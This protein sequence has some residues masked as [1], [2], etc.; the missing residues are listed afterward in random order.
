MDLNVSNGT[1]TAAVTNTGTADIDFDG[2]TLTGTVTNKAGG[3]VDLDLKD[4]A[5]NGAIVNSGT[6]TYDVNGGTQTTTATTVTI[7]NNAN[8]TM[9]IDLGGGTINYHTGATA[10]AATYSKK[11][12]VANSGVLSIIDTIG[13]GKIKTELLLC[14]LRVGRTGD[15]SSFGVSPMRSKRSN[16]VV[17]VEMHHAAAQLIRPKVRKCRNDLCHCCLLM[18]MQIIQ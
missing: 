4:G 16:K 17:L 12:A 11:A 8:S 10:A 5:L 2:G 18:H 3:N 6:F 13:G 7:T 1:I 9:D 14:L 15:A